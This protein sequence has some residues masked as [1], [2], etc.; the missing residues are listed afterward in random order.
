MLDILL[1]KAKNHIAEI[2]QETAL[3]EGV[4]PHEMGNVL[5]DTLFQKFKTDAQRGNMDSVM[6]MFGG[7]EST[8]QSP[9]LKSVAL[10]LSKCLTTKFK[11]DS[12]QADAMVSKFLPEVMNLF[13][14]KIKSGG[15]DMEAILSLF[16]GENITQ[17][18]ESFTEKK[19][20]T[21]GFLNTLK[22][23]FGSNKSS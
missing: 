19:K 4:Q 20:N 15:L 13:N 7:N 18:V 14:D 6:E 11:L 5:G 10:E 23:F 1:E 3:P 8:N 21:S 2:I 9:A 12:P 22:G 17:L 16:K